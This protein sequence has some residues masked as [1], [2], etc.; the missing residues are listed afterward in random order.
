M[1]SR[2]VSRPLQR[3][4][5]LAVLS[6]LVP[7]CGETSISIDD[8]EPR[9]DPSPNVDLERGLV[10]YLPLD[11]MEDYTSTHGGFIHYK[12]RVHGVGRTSKGMNLAEGSN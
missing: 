3:F 1:V 9:T 8:G 7:A 12:G 11:E 2:V 4:S 5:A 6:L 10:L